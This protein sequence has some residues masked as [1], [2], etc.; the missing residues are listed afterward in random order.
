MGYFSGA[1]T[2]RSGLVAGT[3][4]CVIGSVATVL[5]TSFAAILMSRIVA[6]LVEGLLI[7][8]V[9]RAVARLDEPEK[10][11]GQINALMN[12]AGFLLIL[13]MPVALAPLH[14]DRAIFALLAAATLI[15]L[16]TVTAYPVTA[17]PHGGAGVPRRYRWLARLVRVRGGVADI[18]GRQLLLSRHGIT[19]QGIRHFRGESRFCTVDGLR[20]RHHRFLRRSLDRRASRPSRGGTLVGIGLF[21]AVSLLVHAHSGMGIRSRHVPLRTLLVPWARDL[22]GN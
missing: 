5:M 13:S 9:N 11:Y 15:C 7:A 14:V 21:C 6:G 4:L 1:R 19:R 18:D 22:S 2:S 17:A 10:R 12:L 8:D 3:L 20:R 16:A